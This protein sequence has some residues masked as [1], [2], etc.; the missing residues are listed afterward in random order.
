M[1]TFNIIIN[2]N[3][4]KVK[5]IGKLFLRYF[6]SFCSAWGVCR[7]SAPSLAP[8]IFI[9]C[10][11]RFFQNFC[12]RALFFFSACA[13]LHG[14]SVTVSENFWTILFQEFR[15]LLSRIFLCSL[16]IFWCLFIIFLCYF[17]M[18]LCSYLSLFFL[19]NI[20]LTV[21]CSEI[22]FLC[23]LIIFKGVAPRFSLFPS[24]S[25]WLYYTLF[26]I[27][28]QHFSSCFDYFFVLYCNL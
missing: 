6:I 9:F 24:T 15:T 18:F 2:S 7:P 25:L 3:S 4:E 17:I 27:V 28:C 11:S 1:P 13:R 26:F 22:I 19:C 14:F 12:A 8:Q 16:A 21:L 5:D 20:L 10:S 23:T